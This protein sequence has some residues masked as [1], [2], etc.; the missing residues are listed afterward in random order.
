MPSITW[1]GTIT[2]TSSIAQAGDTRGIVS[3]LRREQVIQ[4]DGSSINIPVISGNSLRGRLRRIGEE[5]MRDVLNYEG[6]LSTPAAHALRSGGSL[7]KVTEPLSGSRLAQIRAHLPLIAVFGAAAGGRIIDGCLEVGKLIPQVIETNHITGMNSTQSAYDIVQLEQYTRLDDTDTHD[8]P[9]PSEPTAGE[10]QMLYRLET[11]KAGTAFSLTI[12][13]HRPT[14]IE[15]AFFNTLWQTFVHRP[16][17]GGRLAIGLGHISAQGIH[18][19]TNPPGM[20][21]AEFLRSNRDQA[22]QALASL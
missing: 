4:P 22:M 12:H 11:Y 19:D 21:W 17:I 1:S 10:N 7:T 9:Q 16:R 3:M 13:L 20:D 8:H 2:A 14:D 5:L 18:P 15:A 6:Q